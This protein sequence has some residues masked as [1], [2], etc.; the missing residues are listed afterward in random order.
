MTTRISR[1]GPL[2]AK[3]TFRGLAVAAVVAGAI[4]IYSWM[5]AGTEAETQTSTDQPTTPLHA[6][7]SYLGVVEEAR[8]EI[9]SIAEVESIGD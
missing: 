9:D 8:A 2:T 7:L 4:G 5:P 6:L 3:K 1:V